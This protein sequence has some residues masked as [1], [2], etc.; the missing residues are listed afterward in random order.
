MLDTLKLS[1]RL[2]A[3]DMPLNQAEALAEGL[4]ESLKESY[5]TR[6]FLDSRLM[7]T[8]AHFDTKLSTL[9][10]RIDTRLAALRSEMVMWMFGIVGIGTL[11]ITSGNDRPTPT[12]EAS[13]Q[14]PTRR[15]R[16]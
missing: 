9:E 4:A 2:T 1:K 11:A 15:R 12:T 7:A 13:D 14:A 10:G 16:G 5:V 3:A 6:E 8:E